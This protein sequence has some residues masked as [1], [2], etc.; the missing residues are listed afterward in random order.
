MYEDNRMKKISINGA[1]FLFMAR[2]EKLTED[3]IWNEAWGPHKRYV[4]W[5]RGEFWDVRF[6]KVENGK[7]E[8]LPVADGPIANEGEAWQAAYSHWNEL[9]V[10]HQIKI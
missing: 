1:L 10:Y 8:W 2:G 7:L 5:P 6:K 9:P 4:F 3:A